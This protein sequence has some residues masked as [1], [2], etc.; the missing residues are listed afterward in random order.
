MGVQQVE[1]TVRY[2]DENGNPHEHECFAH[3]AVMLLFDVP[4]LDPVDTG[5]YPPRLLAAGADLQQQAVAASALYMH[6]VQN[7]V[8]HGVLLTGLRSYGAMLVGEVPQVIMEIADGPSKLR[9]GDRVK[10]DVQ[11]RHDR[12]GEWR[13]RISLAPELPSMCTPWVANKRVVEEQATYIN[14]I[15]G[16]T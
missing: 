4:Y 8:P 10:V 11:H 6:L 14:R 2:I 15:L 16:D 12:G 1:V 13:V 9:V 7:G 3:A 5:R